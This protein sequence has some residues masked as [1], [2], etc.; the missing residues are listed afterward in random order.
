MPAILMAQTYI[1]AGIH[2]AEAKV[3]ANWV[4]N[5]KSWFCV[6]PLS[7]W[8]FTNISFYSAKQTFRDLIVT[9]I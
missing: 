9:T 8:R 5:P 2:L 6:A 3:F 7:V 4:R 1:I